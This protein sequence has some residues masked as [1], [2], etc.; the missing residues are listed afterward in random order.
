MYHSFAQHHGWSFDVLEHMT[1]EIGQ[2]SV[3]SKHNKQFCHAFSFH[4]HVFIYFMLN[5]NWNIPVLVFFTLLIQVDYVTPRPVSAAPRA[6]RDWSSKVESIECR[7]FPRLR[8]R[9]ECTPAPWLWL[10]SPNPQ[11][12]CLTGG[13]KSVVFLQESLQW[14][15]LFCWDGSIFYILAAIACRMCVNQKQSTKIYKKVLFGV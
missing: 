4:L 11:R 3:Q 10:Y 13:N 2:W 6:T 8:N 12:Y 5:I 14:K 1:S 15:R 7:G 9:V